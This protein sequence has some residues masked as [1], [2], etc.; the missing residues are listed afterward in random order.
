MLPID[1]I[2][3]GEV[4]PL[5]PDVRGL[6]RGDRTVV[7]TPEVPVSWAVCMNWDD[8]SHEA[9]SLNRNWHQYLVDLVAASLWDQRPRKPV[10]VFYDTLSGEVAMTEC[11]LRVMFSSYQDETYVRF[12]EAARKISEHLDWGS[13]YVSDR[14]R[15]IVL[16][17]PKAVMH[18]LWPEP[19]DGAEGASELCIDLGEWE[20]YRS[21]PAPS[22]AFETMRDPRS[23]LRYCPVPAR[24]VS[25]FQ[26][27][28]ARYAVANR[29]FRL[30]L[31]GVADDN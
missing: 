5:A 16:W 29:L 11:M 4:C 23:W 25:E 7:D 28:K 12:F 6:M 27:G 30:A 8:F 9:M 26:V 22:K 14:A 3:L 19:E 1:T 17:R 18:A 15:P 24:E 21:E 2:V 20:Q 13:T 10:L 31:D